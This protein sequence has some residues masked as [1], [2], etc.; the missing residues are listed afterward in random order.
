VSHRRPSAGHADAA[1]AAGGATAVADSPEDCIATL[2]TAA[3]PVLALY[4]PDAASL[5]VVAWQLSQWLSPTSADDAT[6]PL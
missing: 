5:R 4:S 6:L 2:G 1:A 3:V